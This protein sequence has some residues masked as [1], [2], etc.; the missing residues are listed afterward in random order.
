MQ[1]PSEVGT[2]STSITQLRKIEPQVNRN[3]AK[4]LLFHSHEEP[5]LIMKTPDR[6][7]LYVPLVYMHQGQ[8]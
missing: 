4:G 2:R 6:S 7:V 5:L 8:Q 3:Q 1:Q